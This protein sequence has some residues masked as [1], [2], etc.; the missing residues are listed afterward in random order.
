VLWISAIA[1]HAQTLPNGVASGDVT[2]GGIV[3]WTRSLALGP[4]EFEVAR[5]RGFDRIVRRQ[6]AEVTD[7]DLPVKVRVGW[8]APATDYFYRAT[9]AAGASAAGRFRTLPR[10]GYSRG[11]RFGVSGDVAGYQKPYT[12]I[13]NVAERDLDFF[14][15]LGDT[16]YA[17][18]CTPMLPRRA[19]TLDQFRLKHAEIYTATDDGSNPMAELRATTALL[20]T[21]D[22]HEVI[23]DFAGGAPPASDDRFDDTGEFINETDLFRNAIQAFREYHPMLERDTGWT[24]D[25]RTSHK[26]DLYRF[27]LVGSDVALIMLDTRTF[28]DEPLLALQANG[29]TPEVSDLL[30]LLPAAFEPG[31]TMLGQ[32]QLAR[33]KLDLLRADLLGVTWKFVLVPE[34]IQ[35]LGL[36][37][38]WDR[39]EGYAAER[40]E[41]LAFI[42]ENGIRNVVFVAA[43]IHGTVVNNLNYREYYRGP[44]IETSAFEI[45]T[46]AIAYSNTFGGTTAKIFEALNLG[47]LVGLYDALGPA[48]KDW[49]VHVV[50]N[51]QLVVQGHD[52]LGLHR[53]PV[54]AELL[55]GTYWPMHT[56]GWTEF[57]LDRD[58]VLL[59]TTYGIPLDEENPPAGPCDSGHLASGQLEVVSRF[60]VRPQ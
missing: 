10:L 34:P 43:D 31:R 49:L 58:G 40:A 48:G 3:L 11:V 18:S 17:D 20:A 51:L 32:A 60:R 46:G 7:P 24:G 53:S 27:R 39:F 26:P 21:I 25:P 35:N 30:A 23:N 14:V 28:R 6:F 9:D 12:S 5:D 55:E 16:A 52:T 1:T 33:F 59:V 19:V 36:F 37:G 15:N 56:R 50:L 38:A 54:E 42:H 4:V 45:S 44:R 41:I 47:P 29:P 8:L 22:D 57:E 2:A 13:A